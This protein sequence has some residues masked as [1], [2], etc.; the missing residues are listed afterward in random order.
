VPKIPYTP[1]DENDLPFP[2]RYLNLSTAQKLSL[3][4]PDRIEAGMCSGVFKVW[5][6]DKDGFILTVS[7]DV[8]VK[9]D[10]KGPA[11]FYGDENCE[12]PITQLE[13]SKGQAQVGFWFKASETIPKGFIAVSSPQLTG[14]IRVVT[15]S[16]NAVD[17]L[18][19]QKQ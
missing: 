2:T 1:W 15:V 6:R 13:L 4:L 9:L 17:L 7:D 14:E 10:F 19:K 11:A 18:S 16:A 3:Q 5:S 12:V 8:T